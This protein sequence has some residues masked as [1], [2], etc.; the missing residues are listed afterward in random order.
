MRKYDFVPP[1]IHPASY[2]SL[3]LVRK[4]GDKLWL[5]LAG[6]HYIC[7]ELLDTGRTNALVRVVAPKDLPIIRGE[8]LMG[9]P[10]GIRVNDWDD[11]PAPKEHE[12]EDRHVDFEEEYGG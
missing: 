9:G 2:G 4:I 11:V 7:V 6:N 8:S 10:T 3:H 12:I 5:P 1:D